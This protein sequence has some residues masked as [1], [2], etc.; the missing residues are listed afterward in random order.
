MAAIQ[1]G[2]TAQLSRLEMPAKT[3][4]ATPPSAAIRLAIQKAQTCLR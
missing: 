2:M 3:I 4:G 1:N